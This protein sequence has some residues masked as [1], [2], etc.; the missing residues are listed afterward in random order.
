VD[1]D[2]R[3]ALLRAAIPADKHDELDTIT[4]LSKRLADQLAEIAAEWPGVPLDPDR[5]VERVAAAVTRRVDEPVRRVIETMPAADLYLAAACTEGDPAALATFRAEL[6]PGLRQALGTLALPPATIDE[7]VQRVLV[8]LFV[9]DAPQIAGY[10]GRGRLRSWLRSVGVRTGRRL[11][12]ELHGDT[13]ASSDE[14]DELPAAVNDPELELL[15]SRYV[16][17][18]RAAFA[19]AL[20]SLNERPRML[21]RQY[22]IDGLTID[23]LAALYRINRATA[24]R[25]VASARSEVVT[26]TR[27][28]L[29]AG[30]IAK[31]EVDSVIR[32]VRSQLSVSLR[33]L[34]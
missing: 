16:G 6:L 21:L 8:I 28:R 13:G 30:G 2:E 18:V 10:T 34:R 14:L 7:T 22:H 20:A 19:A 12:G 24:A 15:R 17:D 11:A 32:L 3:V 31:H 9:G 23:Q 33:E 25:W 5:Y 1:V 27:A 29:V 26:E 4:D